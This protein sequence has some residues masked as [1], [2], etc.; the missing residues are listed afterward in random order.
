M[1]NDRLKG[2]KKMDC[3]IFFCV[4]KEVEEGWAPAVGVKRSDSYRCMYIYRN[5]SATDLF[6][7]DTHLFS[8]AHGCLRA[9]SSSLV[10]RGWETRA[11]VHACLNFADKMHVEGPFVL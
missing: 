11:C 4:R 6:C 10:T 5:V 9:K 1:K 8:H 3:E 2:I 7:S